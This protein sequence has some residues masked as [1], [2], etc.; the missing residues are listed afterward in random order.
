VASWLR[1][2]A[3]RTAGPLIHTPRSGMS[4]TNLPAWEQDAD[5]HGLAA[6]GALGRMG[7]E[8]RLG[9]ILGSHHP[10][11][12]TLDEAVAVPSLQLAS[13]MLGHRDAQRSHLFVRHGIREHAAV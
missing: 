4:I 7:R 6:S 11:P 3:A 10:R 8:A 9:F 2:R 12:L 13:S 5:L 1:R